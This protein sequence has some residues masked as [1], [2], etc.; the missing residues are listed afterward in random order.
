MPTIRITKSEVDK[1]LPTGR[2]L[3]FWDAA[4]AGFGLKVS[5]AGAKTYVVQYRTSGGRSGTTRRV[6]VGKH[7]SPWTAD[8]ARNEAKRILGQV[9]QGEDPVLARRD[10]KATLTVA[11]LCDKYLAEGTGTKKES[12]L[13][14]DRGRIERHI[15]PLLGGRK[16]TEVTPADIRKFLKSV[17]EGATA[18]D[19]KTGIRGRAIVKGGKGTASRTIGLLGGIF[20]FAIELGLIK[21]NPVH[22]VP[23]YADKKNERFLSADELGL[24]GNALRE[25]AE[26]GINP[27]ALAIIKLLTFTGARRGEIER[28]RWS[29]VDIVGNRLRL[30]DSKTGQKSVPLNSAAAEVLEELHRTGSATGEFV[31]PA[32]EGMGHYQGTPRVWSALRKKAGLTD[33]RLHDLRHSFASVGVAGGT[34]LMIVGALL[35]HSNHSTTQRYAHLAANPVLAAS[36]EIGEAMRKA[37][38]KQV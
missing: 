33:V 20:T 11:E 35:G 15:K 23:R 37:L 14:T 38:A 19:V 4:V 1:V 2:D 3:I 21:D 29:E 10:R 28:L 9:A 34:S 24:V 7:G 5:A 6:T 32:A 17:A 13:A 36:E 22:G 30:A 27:K 18:T 12:T 25:G 16:V 8:A 31:F 26:G